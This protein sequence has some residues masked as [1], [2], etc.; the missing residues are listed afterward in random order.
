VSK[1]FVLGLAVIVAGLLGYI[2]LFERGSLSSKEL[3]ERKGRVLSTFVRDHVTQLELT[4]D[5]KTLVLE[6]KLDDDGTFAPWKLIKPQPAEADQDSVDRLLGELEWLSARRILEHLQSKELAQLGLDKPRFRVGYRVSGDDHVFNVG[7]ADALGDNF[8][9][10]YAGEDT[11]YVVP[12]TL[13]E[14]LDH[15]LGHFRAKEFLGNITSAWAERLTLTSSSERVS[16]QK[17]SGKWWVVEARAAA[18]V[19][20][21]GPVVPKSYADERRV[22]ELVDKLDSLRAVRFLEGAQK[23]EAERALRAQ[24]LSVELRVVPDV[25]REDRAAERFLLRIGAAC[26]GHDGER[27]AQ[28]GEHGDPVCVRAEDVARFE[29]GSEDLR[30]TRL[31]GADPSE[32]ERVEIVAGDQ[33]WVL[34]RDGEKWAGEG[35]AAPD[36]EAVEAWLRDLSETRALGFVA[37]KALS[38]SLTLRLKLASESET[39]I[40]AEVTDGRELLIQR[41]GEPVCARF[42]A[43]AWERLRPFAGRFAELTLW[44]GRQPSQVVSLSARSGAKARSLVL[45]DQTFRA[46]KGAAPSADADHVRELVRALVRLTAV[47]VI[48]DRPLPEQKL[49]DAG[50]GLTLTLSGD[51][52]PPLTLELG[53]K[54]ER[55]RYARVDGTRVVEVE[56]RVAEMLAELASG[57]WKKEGGRTGGEGEDA[58]AHGDEDED[59]HEDDHPE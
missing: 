31:F 56:E 6:R 36:R 27:Y 46:R 7:N 5:G 1:R 34:K 55:G 39:V 35:L 50:A 16:L 58:H 47:S 19:R 18:P 21:E 3:D 33:R 24:N 17:E 9:A 48:S 30:L 28:A 49:E 32:I 8:Y 11:V 42:S 10:A 4:R 43:L 20:T 51:A 23:D 22:K 52:G 2:A 40:S 14:A 54:S 15:E 59:V 53:D 37:K 29:V 26:A 45:D 25:H 44:P 41:E 13:V 12:K 38:P 57:E